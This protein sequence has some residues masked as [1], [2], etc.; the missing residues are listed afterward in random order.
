LALNTGFHFGAYE[1]LSPL[2]VG[3][4]GEVYRARDRK[5]NRDVALKILP[6]TF[7]RDS[8]RLAR[9]TREAQVLAALNH[10]NIAAIYHVEDADGVTALV[11]ELVE[12]E[13]LADRIARGAIPVDDALP[14]AKQIA[15][16]L[17][18]AHE[19][20]IIHR[21]LKPANIKITRDRRIKVLDFGIAKAVAVPDDDETIAGATQIGIVVG[22]P[23]YMSPEQA[24]GEAVGFQSDIWSFGAVL[25]EM[26]TGVSPFKR[27]T[28]AETVARVLESQ[29][30][31]GALPP[32]TPALVGLLL[33]RC[34]ERDRSRRLQ[35]MGDVRI[36][37]EEALAP[38]DPATETASR[39]AVRRRGPLIAAGVVAAVLA[40]VAIGI[41]ADRSASTGPTSPLYVS[42]PFEGRPASYTF[43]TRQ[44]AISPD[45]S[46]VAFASNRGLQIRHIDQKDGAIILTGG[47][48]P[49]FSPDGDWVGLFHGDTAMVKVPVRGGTPVS[50]TGLTDRPFGASWRADGTIVFATTEGLFEVSANGGEPKAI[51]RPDR[52]RGETLYA[53]PHF[54][55][56]GGSILYTAVSKDAKDGPQT[57]LLDLKS[58]E[59]KALVRGSS[60][61]YDAGGHLVYSAGSTLNAIA[62]DA[63][64]GVVTGKPVAI[65]GIEVATSTDDFAA[66]FAISDTGTLVVLP[67]TAADRGTFEWIDR[68]GQL[69][70]LDIE[71]QRYGYAMVSPDGTRVALERYTNGIRNIW[72]LDL[73]RLTQTQLTDGP[74]EDNLPVWSADGQRVFFASNRSGNFDV[75]S[76]A[77]DGASSA[78]LVFAASGFQAPSATT[79]DGTRLLIYDRFDD[80]A[81]LNLA[82]PDHLEPLLHSGFD[83]RLGQI[84]RDGRWIAYE[85]NESGNQFEIILRS[86]PDVSAR[87]EILSINGGR[88]PRWGPKGFDELYY[89][90]ADGA[91]M[92]VPVTLSPALVLGTPKKL[93]DWQKPT[94]ARSGLRYDVAPDGRFLMPKAQAPSADVPTNISLIVNWLADLRTRQP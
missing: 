39:S 45:G 29:P 89:L 75:Y 61:V 4:M 13:T 30:D 72:I 25:Y 85:S 49:F 1:I 24:R 60:A 9:F 70:P 92:A 33:G 16:A 5:L 90:S 69:E 38:F 50:I 18:A 21:D 56:G 74:I 52:G 63:A 15:D 87:R 14:I 94:P 10:P 20:S 19:Q 12:G 43:G 93:F 40:G 54:L 58:H 81:I 26:L 28:G 66:N 2:G 7:A 86:F 8:A 17:E 36:L 80:L 65:P 68:H 47:N 48:N 34:L 23:A 55:P 53:W 62:F 44:I 42:V 11:M 35:H 6:D 51:A 31:Y 71:P 37:I 27:K 3:G 41:L 79:P 84:S 67:P 32:G 73:K 83:E 88:Y 64:T 22:T 59:R 82:K 57:M 76:Q 77:A 91:I 46:T 78:T